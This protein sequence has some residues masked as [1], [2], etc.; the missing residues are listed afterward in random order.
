MVSISHYL[1]RRLMLGAAILVGSCTITLGQD[2]SAPLPK[3]PK[4]ITGKLPNGLT[5]Y[6]RPNGKPEKKVELRLAVNT[7]SIMEDDDQ[8]GLAHFMEHMN[9][10]GTKNFKK[11]ELVSYLQSIGVQFGADLNAYTGFDETVYILPIPTDKPGNL[12]KGFQIIEDW[13]H[14]AL[15]TNKDIDDERGVVLEESRMGKGAEDRMMHQYLPKLMVGSRYANRLPIGKDDILKNFKYDVLRRFYTDWYRPDM[16]AVAVAGDIDSATAMQYILKHFAGLKNPAKPRE[17][18]YFEVPARTKAEAMVVTDKEATNYQLQMMF[19]AKKATPNKTLGDYRQSLAQ[20]LVTSMI[21]RRLNDLAKSSNPPFPFAAVSYGEEW[22]RGYENFSAFA[23]F[24]ENG[25]EAAL[26]GLT[27]E[28]VRAKQFGFNASELE[29][30]R[31]GMMSMIE[32]AYN[33]RNTTESGAYV[34]EYVRNFLKGEPIPGIENE[35]QYYQQLLPGIQLNELN[36]IIKDWLSNENIFTLITGPAKDDSKLPDN[37]ALLAMVQKGLSQ[38]VTPLEEK[39]VS[40][41]L[42]TKKPTPGKVTSQEKDAELGVTTYTLSNGIKVTL[43]QTDFKSDEI[44][45]TGIKKGGTNNY[46]IADRSNAKYAVQVAAS[47]G[48]GDFAPSDLEKAT[49]GKPVSVKMAMQPIQNTISGNSNVKDFETMLQLLHLR[50]TAPRKDEALFKAFV[51]KQKT[52]IAFLTQNPQIKFFDTTLSVLY[53]NHPLAPSPFPKAKEFDELN[54]ERALEIYKAEYTN[55]DG[56]HF[57]FVG[58]IDAATALPL[59]ETYIGSIAGANRKPEFKD[60]GVRPVAGMIN[61]K[62]GTEKQSFIVASYNGEAPYSE[63]F[64]LK[65][66]AVAEVLN[67]KVIEEMREKLGSIYTGGYYANVTKFPYPHYSVGMQ[68]PCG[69]ENVDKLLAAANEEIKMLKEKGPDQKDVD[70]VKNQWKEAHRTEVKENKYWTEALADV[71]FWGNDKNS[72]LR[73]DA[74]VDSITPADIQQTA[75]KMFDGKNGFISVL[76]PENYNAEKPRSSN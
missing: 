24:G 17:R 45:M 4:V 37:A 61:V 31:K 56:Y 41:T 34:N 7:G 11:N 19:P 49:A 16:Q 65:A 28:L 10:N 35:Y 15:L 59:I 64:K 69:P 52:Q 71:L 29:L 76:Y 2:L 60:N 42:I 46:G 40:N 50:L 48:F 53:Q 14:N 22:A 18:K 1:L 26:N 43:K 68:L 73:Y 66:E 30:A 12:E 3:D 67:I 39:K 54:M 21:N 47:M 72:V 6:I 44:L 58:N 55:A 62:K 57:F 74:L 9:F 20:Q 33:E 75:K 27:A 8:Q 25:P 70:K 5:Y 13:A 23:L 32:K 36:A 38:Q 63:D 51:D